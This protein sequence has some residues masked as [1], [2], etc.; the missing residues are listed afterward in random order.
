MISLWRE[1]RRIARMLRTCP[2]YKVP[3]AQY[4]NPTV[5]RGLPGR[6]TR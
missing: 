4:H 6:W 2:I 5:M 3:R 1:R